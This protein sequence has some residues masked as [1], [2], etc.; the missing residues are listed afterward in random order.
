FILTTVFTIFLFQKASGNSS[1]A[2]AI[3]LSWLLLQGLLG[4]TGF[5]QNINRFPPPISMLIFPPLLLIIILFV[6]AAGKRFIDQLNPGRLTRLHIIRIPVEIVLYMLYLDHQVPQIMTFAGGNYDIISGLTAPVIYYYG[7]V[8]KSIGRKILFT[9]NMICLGLL[10]NIVIRAI[11]SSPSPFQKLAFDQP[12]VAILHFPYNWLPSLLVPLVIS[13]HL[14]S[15]L[16][17]PKKT[18]H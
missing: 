17:R 7:Y 9:W 4:V 18:I 12:N 15:I 16:P 8:K 2:L 3:I 13:S 6:T 10:L 1:S 14:V 11:L 5:Y